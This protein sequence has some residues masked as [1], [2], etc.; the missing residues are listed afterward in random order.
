MPRKKY[1]QLKSEKPVWGTRTEKRDMGF[2]R[3]ELES[4]YSYPGRR[5]TVVFALWLLLGL[6]GGHR[7][8]MHRVF[9]GLFQ[10][11]TFGGLGI[12]WLVDGLLLKRMV[13]RFNQDQFI[14]K[15]TG[16]PPL[17]L[18]FMPTQWQVLRP[19]PEWAAKRSSVFRLMGDCLVLVVA[20]F[21]L[22]G[23]A[24]SYG[25]YE[26][27]AA[28][29]IL[30]AI[31]LAGP[32][33]DSIATIPVLRAFDRWALRL[34]LFYYVNDPGSPLSL[35]FRPL[36]V[37]LNLTRRRARTEARLYLQIGA[38]FA[39]VFLLLDIAE[40]LTSGEPL[41]LP[42]AP[43]LAMATLEKLI[44]VYGFATPIGSVLTKQLLLQR[45][46]GVLWLLSL[47]VSITIFATILL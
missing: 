27:V 1:R 43:E 18:D 40:V 8:Y 31:T 32:R 20:S 38:G 33:W 9:S 4:L 21:S 7:F 37:V 24:S 35:L 23:Y 19:Q 44:A 30:M 28:I 12:W 14:R 11:L 6:V 29:M 16:R 47:V 13:R 34:R 45:R 3:V 26:P 39:V 46:D 42:A 36:T 41:D 5:P 15:E 17:A 10:L 2:T 22:G 25:D